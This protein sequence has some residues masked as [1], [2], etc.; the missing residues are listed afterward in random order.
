[1]MALVRSVSA[2]RSGPVITSRSALAS[3]QQRIAARCFAAAA[4][5]DAK[6][7]KPEAEA[8]TDKSSSGGSGMGGKIALGFIA[9]AFAVLVF[10]DYSELDKDIKQS[11]KRRDSVMR[12]A[13]GG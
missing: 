12:A 11:A 5:E 1:M 3:S 9:A 7:A 8:A 13:Q 10:E 2:R 4:G 6:K